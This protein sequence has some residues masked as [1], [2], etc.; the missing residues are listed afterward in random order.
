MLLQKFF[1]ILSH[2]H[3]ISPSFI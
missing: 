2:F 3:Y 1:L